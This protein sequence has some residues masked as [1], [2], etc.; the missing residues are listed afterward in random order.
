MTFVPVQ[1]LAK[2]LQGFC[3]CPLP[4]G[5]TTKHKGK[6]VEKW[7][8]DHR[9]NE[10]VDLAPGAAYQFNITVTQGEKVV[11]NFVSLG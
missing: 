6:S 11:W 2:M 5:P 9:H 4:L 8:L 3:P 1:W 10:E 7:I